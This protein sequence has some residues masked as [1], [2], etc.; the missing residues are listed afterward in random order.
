ME[1]ICPQ[2]AYLGNISAKIQ[3]VRISDILV[4]S[5]SAICISHA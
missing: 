5:E 3:N 4:E 2:P 1:A